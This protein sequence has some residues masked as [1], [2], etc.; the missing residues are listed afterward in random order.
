MSN[1]TLYDF[2]SLPLRGERYVTR[3]SNNDI[4]VISILAPSVGSARNVLP[5][6]RDESDFNSRSL[7]GERYQEDNVILFDL[8]ISILVPCVGS[9]DE[10]LREAKAST[11]SILALRMGSDIHSVRCNCYIWDFNSRSL[12]GVR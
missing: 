10:L 3:Q 9:D 1:K 11:I 5:D 12:R 2:N 7:L 4:I 8:K 6:V